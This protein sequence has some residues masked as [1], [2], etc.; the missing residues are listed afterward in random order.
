MKGFR[1]Q[2]LNITYPTEA[3]RAFKAGNRFDANLGSFSTI[4]KL[5]DYDVMTCFFASSADD[6]SDDDDDDDDDDD[7]GDVFFFLCWIFAVFFFQRFVEFQTRMFEW[8]T[9]GRRSHWEGYLKKTVIQ[10]HHYGE[11]G[12]LSQ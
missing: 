3:K 4:S 8:S 12:M 9:F 2:R 10:R 11:F 6:D 1:S 7:G 5:E